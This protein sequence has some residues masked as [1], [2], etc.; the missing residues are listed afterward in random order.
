MILITVD[1]TVTNCQISA[2]VKDDTVGG[3]GGDVG[4]QK[5]GNHRDGEDISGKAGSTVVPPTG[6]DEATREGQDENKVKW[7]LHFLSF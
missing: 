7:L 6:N 2:A 1:I 3:T 4:G 5:V